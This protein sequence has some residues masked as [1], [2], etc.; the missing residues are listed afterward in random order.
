MIKGK[1]AINLRV[2][3]ETWRDLRRRLSWREWREELGG[4]NDVSLKTTILEGGEII[5]KKNSTLLSIF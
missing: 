1:E 5:M 4:G 3:R 2:C